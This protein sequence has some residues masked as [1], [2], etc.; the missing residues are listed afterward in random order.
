MILLQKTKAIKKH[1]DFIIVGAGMAG[2]ILALQLM[3]RGKRVL[4]FDVPSDNRCSMVAAGLCNPVTGKGLTKTWLA[5]LLF[6]YLHQF[7]QQ[8]SHQLKSPFFFPTR[9]YRPFL[10]VE[11]QNEWM[12]VSSDDRLLKFIEH[13]YTTSQFNSQVHDPLGGLLVREA[14]YVQTPVFLSSVRAYL[15]QHDS[16]EEKMIADQDI[17][18][19][20]D[21]VVV[22]GFTADHLIFC[23]GIAARNT[24]WFNWV[25]LQALKGETLTV[26]SKEDPQVVYNRSV[27]LVPSMGGM[28]RVGATYNWKDVTPGITATAREELEQSLRQ[29]VTFECQVQ[30]QDWGIRPTIADRKPILGPHPFW[31][32]LWFFNG[33]GTKGVS[34][35]PYFAAQ[36]AE[37][38]CGTGEIHPQVNIN[39][40]Y[41]LYSKSQS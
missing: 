22:S 20:S 32:R 15:L 16:F 38:L 26:T 28:F 33:L 10:T 4:V 25:P 37:V 29:L 27:Y 30:R 7:Y 39:R 36:L 8:T 12:G 6:P 41:P 23:N 31:Q 18:M 3:N 17:Q 19:E 2:S 5:D 11:E 24:S 35:S 40:F 1:V 21:K 14:A 34:L 9:L 13:V